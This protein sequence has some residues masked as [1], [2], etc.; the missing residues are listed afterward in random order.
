MSSDL[1]IDRK[2]VLNIRRVFVISTRLQILFI[3]S[4]GVNRA[5]GV[6]FGPKVGQI[7]TN[8]DKSGNFK[9][10]ISVHFGLQTDREIHP[11]YAW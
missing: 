10:H 4:I 8:W 7:S 11:H 6:R 3:C 9:D 2:K 1:L 5:R